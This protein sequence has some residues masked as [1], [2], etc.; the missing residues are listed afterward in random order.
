MPLFRHPEPDDRPSDREILAAAVL[1]VVV[2]VLWWL[3]SVMFTL[4]A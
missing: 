4:T 3:V 2:I 1:F